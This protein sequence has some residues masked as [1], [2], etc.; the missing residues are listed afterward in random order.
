[1][2]S[3]SRDPVLSE[4]L[5]VNGSGNFWRYNKADSRVSPD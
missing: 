4:N 3:I 2:R 1:M 5:A